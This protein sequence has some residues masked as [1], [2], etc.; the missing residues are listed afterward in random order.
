MTYFSD[1][2]VQSAITKNKRVYDK[3]PINSLSFL[4][5]SCQGLFFGSNSPDDQHNSTCKRNSTQTG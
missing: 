5:E 2:V 1:P 3:I 4:G